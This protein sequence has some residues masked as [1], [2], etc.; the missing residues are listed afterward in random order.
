MLVNF[1][2][3][4]MNSG[5]SGLVQLL[6]QQWLHYTTNTSLEQRLSRLLDHSGDMFRKCL[7]NYVLVT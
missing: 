3:Y 1:G 6:E 5:Y 7:I 2:D 4:V